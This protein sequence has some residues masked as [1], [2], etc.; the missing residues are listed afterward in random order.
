VLPAVWSSVTTWNRVSDERGASTIRADVCMEWIVRPTHFNL[1]DGSN[2]FL[3]NVGTRI[4]VLTVL[5]P[6][7]RESEESLPYIPQNLLHFSTLCVI[8]V[9]VICVLDIVKFLR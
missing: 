2:V 5:H 1:E 8:N 9:R 4:Q 3:P 7:R 6:R